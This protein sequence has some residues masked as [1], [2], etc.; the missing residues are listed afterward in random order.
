M[1][2]T[3]STLDGDRPYARLSTFD[4]KSPDVLSS[5]WTNNG[6]AVLDNAGG[7][8]EMPFPNMVSKDAYRDAQKLTY[9]WKSKR[10]VLPGITTFAAAKILHDCG[11]LRFRVYV[12]GCCT[13][14]T[15]V[16]SQKPFTLPPSVQGVEYEFELEG[17][18]NVYELHIAT[19]TEDLTE[20]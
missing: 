17:T 18:A 9:S 5:V 10:F 14:D 16:Y 15:P 7:V 12:D 20:Q 6:L 2:D 1:F 19:S 11:T 3:G 13:Y 4:Y 8:W